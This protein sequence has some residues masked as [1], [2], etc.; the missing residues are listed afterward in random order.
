MQAHP[1]KT[2]WLVKGKITARFGSVSACA[3][4]LECS[5]DGIRKAVEGKCPGIATRLKE[6]IDFDWEMERA[7]A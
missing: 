1:Y 7:L 6:L 5:Q 3:R 2:W 4:K